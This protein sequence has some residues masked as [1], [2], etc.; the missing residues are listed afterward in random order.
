M[1]RHRGRF[2]N[3]SCHVTAAPLAAK[4]KIVVGAA[5]G[6]HGVRDFI[7]A[8]DGATRKLV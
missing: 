2:T 4:D 3:R 1:R 8:L 7:V 6:D 5:G